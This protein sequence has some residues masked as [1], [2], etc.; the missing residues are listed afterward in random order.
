MAEGTNGPGRSGTQRAAA[1]L[2]SASALSEI[3]VGVCLLA[4]PQLAA[5][6]LDASLDGTGLLVA[7]GLGGAALALGLTWWIARNDARARARCTAGFIIYNVAV[8]ALFAFQALQAARPALPGMVGVVHL[9]AGGAFAA[10][11]ALA[12]A[13]ENTELTE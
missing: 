2:F 7:R 8:G 5:L 11:T 1:L 4:F 6:L 10:A 9:V 3:G 13:R 12:R